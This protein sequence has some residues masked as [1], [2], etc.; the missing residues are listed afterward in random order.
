MKLF[1][2]VAIV[3]AGI[4]CLGGCGDSVEEVGLGSGKLRF[5][6]VRIDEGT[7]VAEATILAIG[8]SDEVGVPE[9]GD[10]IRLALTRGDA[11]YL[12]TGDVCRAK[13]GDS[14]K[15]VFQV[16]GV[17]PDDP[18][19]QERMGQANANLRL[20][21]DRRGESVARDVGSILPQFAVIDQDGEVIDASFFQ[22]KTTLINF[23]FTRCSNPA[24]CPAATQRLKLMLEKSPEFGLS[25]LQVLC[26]TFDPGHDTPGVLKDYAQ[27]YQLDETLFRLGT[28]P[29]QVMDDLRRQ[30]GIAA[31]PDPK[32]IID[33]T[34]RIAVVD[35]HRRIAAEILGPAWAIENTLAR[36]G[37]LI[38]EEEK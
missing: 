23:F 6:I 30:I 3:V 7:F 5:E 36:I 24:M 33:H 16:E 9:R 32:L 10:L 17:W 37:S 31:R 2:L 29:K 13:L 35:G 11:A 34:F 22:G 21:V 19:L 20:D 8:S 1:Q 4:L 18:D 12:K 25:N 27:A 38:Q 28:G 15:G 26:L 14:S